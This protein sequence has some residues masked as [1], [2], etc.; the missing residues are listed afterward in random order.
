M[1][2]EVD[3]VDLEAAALLLELGA[4]SPRRPTNRAADVDALALLEELQPA[5]AVPDGLLWHAEV[6]RLRLRLGAAGAALRA[7]TAQQSRGPPPA[8]EPSATSAA[9]ADFDPQA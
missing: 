2:E 4:G 8:S 7:T 5:D 6:A 9:G 3:E 1:I